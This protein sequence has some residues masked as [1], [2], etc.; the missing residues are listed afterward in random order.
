MSRASGLYDGVVSHRRFAPK[1]HALRYAIFQLLID[2]DE[3]DD[4]WSF[5]N[6]SKHSNSRARRLR[7]A[8]PCANVVR[9]QV[10]H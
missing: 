6:S 5:L 1:V 9:E 2:L 4:F 8:C 3:L 7:R 10:R